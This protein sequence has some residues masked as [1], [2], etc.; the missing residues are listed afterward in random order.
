M[1]EQKQRLPGFIGPANKGRSERFD[2]QRTVNMYLEMDPLGSGKGQEPAVLISTPGLKFQQSIGVGPI[3]ATY[4]QS[5]IIVSWIVSGNQV[6]KITGANAIPQL[7]PGVMWTSTGPVQVS[8]NGTQVIFVDGQYGYYVDTSA[9]TPTL[10]RIVDPNFHP[11]DTVTFQDGYFICVDKGTDGNGTGNFFI[12]DLYSI[13]FLPLNEANASAQSDILVAAMSNNGQLYLLGTKSTEIWYDAGTSGST[14]FQ[15]QTARISQVG[16]AAPN[17]LAVIGETFFWLGSN[18]QGGGV[19][20]S[21][22]N[23]MPVRISNH[24][25][26]YAIQKY[27]DL[28]GATAYSYQQEG[29]YFY[30]LNIPGSHT[31]WVYDV[32]CAQWHERQSQTNGNIGRH[33]G[34]THCVLNG[35]HIVGDY[36]NGNVYVYDLDTYTDNGSVV[37]RIRQSPHVSDSLNRIFYSL[38]EVDMQFGVGLPNEGDPKITLEMSSDG[39][40]T[41]SNPINASLGRTGEYLKRARWQRLGSSRDRVFRVTVTE[42]VRVTMLSAYLDFNAGQA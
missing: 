14:P 17:S 21:L 39:G 1:A 3:R 36:R 38:L 40:Q 37:P 10:V 8:D 32:A 9:V 25:I 42:P 5:N 28:S 12:S 18:A 31:T 30:C 29:H 34:S 2:C 41:W 26:E 27:G 23:A 11:T 16:C 35:Q 7:I 33:Y 13:D 4:T 24:S 19:V 20:Y 15:R 22:D 6:Y